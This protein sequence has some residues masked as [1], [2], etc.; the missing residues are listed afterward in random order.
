M[1][2]LDGMAGDTIYGVS[3][4]D[5]PLPVVYAGDKVFARLTGK[6]GQKF[7]SAIH[8]IELVEGQEME[9]MGMKDKQ[10]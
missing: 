2:V 5:K 4:Y 7:Y 9:T 1:A 6:L 3:G 10:P 8:S